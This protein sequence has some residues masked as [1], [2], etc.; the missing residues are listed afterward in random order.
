[1]SD[2][3]SGAGAVEVVLSPG[4]A[5]RRLGVS[6]SGLRRLATVYAGVYGPLP[7]EAGGTS[8]IWSTEAVGRLERARALMAAGQARSIA[9]A[10]RAVE[11]GAVAT[12][13]AA[14]S[15]G[16]D[17]RVVEALGVVSAQLEAVVESNRRLEREV[18]ALRSEVGELRRLPPSSTVSRDDE[19]AAGGVEGPFVRAAR[20]LER[21]LRGRG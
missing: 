5:A 8:R 14:L 2:E 21:R 6:P 17:G 7:K 20:W 16:R 3:T 19:A 13:A 4:E 15:L 18:E 1:M 9:D 11:G 12:S 10:L